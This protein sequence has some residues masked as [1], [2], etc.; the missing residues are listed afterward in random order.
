MTRPLYQCWTKATSCE[1]GI[2]RRS[3]NWMFARRAW[4]KVFEDRIECGNWSIPFAQ[5]IGGTVY[6]AKQLFVPVTILELRTA[7]SC[8]Q[9]G[10]NPWAS[11]VERLPIQFPE[12]FVSLRN[13]LFS[14]V[15]RL[16]AVGLV[17]YSIL[18]M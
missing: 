12:Q 1:S 18:K 13:S 16:L 6:R 5:V 10:F 9:F 14:I 17:L 3:L 7:K 2:P 8:Y 4:F 11:P 15:V